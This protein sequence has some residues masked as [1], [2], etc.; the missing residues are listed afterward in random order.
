L[1]PFHLGDILTL[2]G[3]SHIVDQ[4]WEW[5]SVS[6]PAMVDH[7]AVNQASTIRIRLVQPMG[8]EPPKVLVLL[9]YDKFPY[10]E[11]FHEIVKSDFRHLVLHDDSAM[12]SDMAMYWRVKN[13]SE[14]HTGSVQLRKIENWQLIRRIEFWDYS[15]MIELDGLETEEFVFVELNADHQSF[16]VWRGTESSRDR[17]LQSQ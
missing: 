5:T 8:S 2:G 12:S 11:S 7:I 14:P 9:L 17:L 4:V 15:R 10:C 16:E 13:A 1:H 3:R 6:A